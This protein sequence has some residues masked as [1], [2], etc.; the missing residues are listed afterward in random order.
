MKNRANFFNQLS[1]SESLPRQ[2]RGKDY[3]LRPL[4]ETLRLETPTPAGQQQVWMRLA[5]R[6]G[7][8]GRPDEVLDA[9]GVPPQRARITRTVLHLKS[10]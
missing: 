7:A 10:S 8:T 2:R 3:D 4:I 5:A 1:E 9:M 6:T